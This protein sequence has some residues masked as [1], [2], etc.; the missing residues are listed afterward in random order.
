[1]KRI[2]Y[3]I[4][5]FLSFYPNIYAQVDSTKQSNKLIFTG[6]VQ[7]DLLFPQEDKSI[8]S[9]KSKYRV[10]TNTFTD[11]NLNYK[12][13][14][15]GVRFEDLKHPLPGFE[16]D[17]K[18]IGLPYFYVRG[19]WNNLDITLGT[20]YEQFGSGFILRTYEER[21]LGI[22]NSLLG[23]RVIYK[24]T[25]GLTFK[26]ITGRQRHY[27]NINK[28]IISGVDAELNIDEWCKSMREANLN[29][30]LGGS[31]VNKYES[32]TNDNIMVDRTHLLNLPEYVNAWD[33][34]MQMIKGGLS[35]LAEYA[36]KTQDPSFAN[37]YIYRSGK[38]AMLSASYSQ[39]GMS[40]LF[41]AKRS[42]DMTF[43]S[44]RSTIGVSSYINHLPAFTQDQTYALAALYP[45]A[46]RPDGEWAY[47]AQFGYK[48]K[49][50]TVIGGRYGMNVKINFS[51]V[52]A[53]DKTL[54][55]KTSLDGKT[56][57]GTKG[58]GS[59]FFKWGK[60]T[61][62]QDFN[63][64]LERKIN[65]NFKLNFMYMNQIYNK[66]V[67]EGEGGM[68]RS[69]I[70]IADGKY[71]FSNKLNLRG[72]IQYLSTKNDQKDWIFGLLELSI[73]P[74]LMFTAS[75]MYNLGSTKIH[76]YQG[77]VTLIYGANRFQLGYGRT[78]SGFNCSGGVCRYVP[79]TKGFTLSYNYNF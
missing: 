72:E 18:G 29:L 8:G 24:P 16:N 30:M 46:T 49:R 5:T 50:K 4:L 6:S 51:H 27:W 17:Y 57:Q 37:G 55:L 21:S 2:Y 54:N 68:I 66:T 53:I 39:N 76:Y 47:Q 78:R 1:M 62:Y 71:K 12:N 60:Q 10:L 56:L 69:N 28:S 25:K 75:D 36:Q 79:A 61:F 14:S 31:F 32:K 77:Y 58:Y 70:F 43:K 26:A 59:V 3:L 35:I 48:F 42:N 44:S 63:V 45:Y 74:H 11:L 64:Q 9:T 15:A 34:R 19:K 52:R 40:F 38:V 7:S 33:I 13:L 22:D 67:I 41:Q 23:G 20:F 65:K 73:V